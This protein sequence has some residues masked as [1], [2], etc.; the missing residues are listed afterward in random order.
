ME[1]R[2]KLIGKLFGTTV[3][4][5]DSYLHTFSIIPKLGENAGYSNNVVSVT[6]NHCCTVCYSIVCIS[7]LACCMISR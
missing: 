1:F 5:G 4:F 3:N 2:P 7:S 6:L